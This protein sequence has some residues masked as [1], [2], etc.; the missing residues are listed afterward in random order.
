MPAIT[1]MGRHAVLVEF[2]AERNRDRND[3]FLCCCCCCWQRCEVEKW[4]RRG[5]RL[6]MAERRRGVGAAGRDMV[7]SIAHSLALHVS[8]RLLLYCATSIIH[9]QVYLT[10]RLRVSVPC[11]QYS[12]TTMTSLE[13]QAHLQP[14][15]FSFQHFNL[16]SVCQ[17]SNNRK[18]FGLV[19]TL[20]K[21]EV[22]VVL[23]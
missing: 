21:H 8:R 17:N 16:I 19:I 5:A 12:D 20:L 15:L 22:F 6:R 10:R 23:S 7:R 4:C 2:K 13:A 11:Y 1:G 14:P 18:F 9:V 3:S